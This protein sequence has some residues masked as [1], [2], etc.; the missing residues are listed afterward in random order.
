MRSGLSSSLALSLL[1][2]FIKDKSGHDADKIESCNTKDEWLLWTYEIPI[3]L[4]HSIKGHRRFLELNMGILNFHTKHKCC[5]YYLRSHEH[6]NVCTFFKSLFLFPCNCFLRLF[7]LPAMER[8]LR[9]SPGTLFISSEYDMTRLRFVPWLSSSFV[10]LH[11]LIGSASDLTRHAPFEVESSLFWNLR[12]NLPEDTSVL[13]IIAFKNM[14]VIYGIAS[15][16]TCNVHE[17]RYDSI[18]CQYQ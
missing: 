9:G 12:R 14:I 6:A 1:N 7:L 15:R 13:M 8:K 16:K 5:Q 18:H 3:S 4:I 10:A 2:V 11:R 17:H